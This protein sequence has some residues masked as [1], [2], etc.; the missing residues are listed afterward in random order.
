MT[1]QELQ[2]IVTKSRNKREIGKY[3]KQAGYYNARYYKLTKGTNLQTIAKAC[4]E[5]C[6]E[7]H[8]LLKI[9]E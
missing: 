6:E 3:L 2:A 4:T 9:S 5:E 8:S 7:V 1:L